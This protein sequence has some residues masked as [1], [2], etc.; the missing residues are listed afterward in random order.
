MAKQ[1]LT[2]EGVLEQLKA[3]F[4]EAIVDAS[5]PYDLL[6]VEVSTDKMH[7]VIKWVRESASLKIDF[8]TNLGGVHYPDDKG[9]E[10]AVVY[11]LHSLVNNFRLRLKAFLPLENLEINSIVD[12][13][14]GA[15]WME[16][17]TYDFFGII[18]KNH[19]NLRRILNED[20]MDYFPMRKEYHLE[21][22]TREDKDDR[23]FGR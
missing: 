21:D 14:V 23:Y 20:S 10:F 18:F 2:N 1:E 19:P 15:N 7:E 16:R 11:H 17:E 22:A 4:G 12:I 13:Y 9:R 8:L 6:T 3:Q 5:T